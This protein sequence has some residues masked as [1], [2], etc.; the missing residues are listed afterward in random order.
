MRKKIRAL[1]FKSG[2]S[3]LIALIAVTTI[4]AQQITVSGTVTSA[5]TGETL[6]GVNIAIVGESGGSVSNLN[7]NYEI[8]VAADATLRFTFIGFEPQLVPVEGRTSIDVELSESTS[9]LDEVLV[10]GYGTISKR[11]ITSSVAQVSGQDLQTVESHDPIDMLQGQMA[12]VVIE[13][14]SGQPG[15]NASITIRGQGSISASSNP[16]YVVDGVIAGTGSRDAVSPSDIASITVLKDAAATALYG[17][18]ASN[19]VVVITTKRGSSGSTQIDVRSSAG[20]SKTLLG[21]EEWMNSQEL[22]DWH[23]QL[24][25]ASAGPFYQRSELL[26]TDVNWWDVGFD[27]GATQNYEASVSGGNDQTTFYLS[28]GY[29]NETGTGVGTN[30]D[31]VSGRVNVQHTFN[32]KLNVS[33]QVAGNY[34]VQNNVVAGAPYDMLTFAAR[35]LPWD[36]PYNEDGTVRTGTEPDWYS[37]DSENPLYGMQWNSE[38]DKTTYFSGDLNLRYNLTDWAYFRTNNRFSLREGR[39]IEF[40]DPRS[41][42]G[43]SRN[44]EIAHDIDRSSSVITSNLLNLNKGWARQSL[45]GLIGFE[46]QENKS[47]DTYVLGT[48]LAPG[49]KILDAA[50]TAFDTDGNIFESAFASMFAQAEYEWDETYIATV[51]FRRDGSSR[52]GANNRWGNFW[53]ASGSWILSKE[54]FLSDVEFLDQLALRASYGTTGNAEIS[55]Y[56]AFGLY[57]FT[58]AYY[59][60]PASWPS[61]TPN[62]DL[63]WEVAKTY[64]IGLDFDF[65]NRFSFSVDV[66]QRDNEDLLQNV[67]LPGTSGI[68]SQLQNVGSVRNKGIEFQIS[69]RNIETAQFSWTTDLTLSSNSN[70]VTGLNDGEAINYGG[71]YRIEEGHDINT[72]YMRKWHGVNPDTGAPQWEVVTRND[73]GEITNVDITEDY[74]TANPQ[75]VGATTPDFQGGLRNVFQYRNFTLNAFFTFQ[76]GSQRYLGGGGLDHGAYMT[77]NKKH[78]QPG[79]SYWRQPGDNATHPA[80]I[81]NGNNSAQLE[82]TLFLYDNSYLRLRNLR[83]TYSLPPDNSLMQSVGLRNALLYASGDNLVTFTDYPGKDPVSGSYPIARVILFGIEVG[84]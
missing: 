52:F 48:G 21:N 33:S 70:T 3:V 24:V 2:F 61:R 12:G 62:P 26:N 67:T 60:I 81:V 7:G 64:N 18:R 39:E 53:S 17:S 40:R 59:G 19:G 25:N 38:E 6:P 46:F 27:G 83:L 82:S 41:Q 54:A 11:Q 10:V 9:V 66:Y 80:Q 13:R 30:Y 16:L 49:M 65:L 78:L 14:T 28:G 69:S 74:G 76:S 37:R 51:S 63:T 50:A 22:Y 4:N 1:L 36:S 29:F 57:E 68:S 20:F 43:G 55:N 34:S 35:N 71:I 84:F 58:R 56:G 15:S 73:A 47:E 8:S 44:G 23:Q 45:S 42:A 77:T 79:E 32:D 31:R 5:V 75:I 72:I